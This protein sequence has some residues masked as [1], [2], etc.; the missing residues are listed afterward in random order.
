VPNDDDQEKTPVFSDMYATRKWRESERMSSDDRG[1]GTP[2]GHTPTPW[3]VWCGTIQTKMVTG[4]PCLSIALMDREPGNGTEPVERDANAAYIVRAC[5][6]HEGLLE[7]CRRA[8][9]VMDTD[10]IPDGDEIGLEL[11]GEIAKA[12]GSEQP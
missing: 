4:K 6:S 1:A 2:V 9:A 3:E 8:L 7:A 10:G 11:M 5:N 12:E